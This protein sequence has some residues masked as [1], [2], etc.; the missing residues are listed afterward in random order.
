MYKY[1]LTIFCSLFIT[2]N[3]SAQQF[4][5]NQNSNEIYLQLK[6]LQ[7]C[8]SVLYIAAH[9]DDENNTLLP[10][11]AKEKLYRTAYLS[12]TRGDGGQNLI[13]PEQGVE[14][15]LIRT[16]ELVAARKIDGAEQYFTRAYEFGFSKSSDETLKIWDKEKVLADVVFVIRKFKPDVIITRFPPDSRAGHGHHAASAIIAHE[17]FVAAADKSKF[18]EQFKFGVNP[19][20]A[21]RIFWNTFNFGTTNTTAEN[22]LKIDVGG[23][24]T[25][26]GKSYGE[27]GAEARSMHKSQGEG[28]ARRRGNLI[29]YF[30]YVNG[31]NATNDLFE[32]VETSFKRFK[33][34]G[35][36]I[37]QL[38]AQAIKNFSF[39]QPSKSVSSLINIYNKIEKLEDEWFKNSEHDNW[40]IKKLNEVK[41]LIEACS[42]L[43]LEAT[44]TQDVAVQGDSLKVNFLAVNRSPVNISI[45]SVKLENYSYQKSTILQY[46]KPLSF[47]TSLLVDKEISQPYW[48]KKASSNEGMFEVA[49]QNLIGK[50]NNEAAFTSNFEIEID[51]K[52]FNFYKPVMYKY[53]DLVRGELYQPL[54]ILPATIVRQK[55]PLVI[56]KP[57]KNSQ[58]SINYYATTASNNSIN[59]L[60]NHQP[61]FTSTE[62]L[63]PFEEKEYSTVFEVSKNNLQ[64]DEYIDSF[65]LQN[66][67]PALYDVQIKYN[68]IPNLIY[69]KPAVQKTLVTNLKV[70]GNKV[71]YIVGAGDKVPEVLEQMGYLVD[72]LQEKDITINNLKQYQ[73]IICG[74]R[75]HNIHEWLSN[76]NNIINE[77]ISNGGNFIVQYLR[78]G[79]V[80]NK[81][82]AVG[83]YNFTVSASSRV[84][85]ENA[86]VNFLL[87]QHKVLN[88][89]N[90]IDSNDFINW[91][92]ERST[93]QADKL[94]SA[95]VSPLQ[96]NDANE[97]PS[98]GS[99]IIAP[100]G[101]GNM[102]YVSLAMFRQMP[103]GVNGALKLMSNI[104]ALQNNK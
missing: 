46:I 90:K 45:K 43:L 18:P 29:E 97:K 32:D 80:G 70:V 104:I 62:K 76:K 100:F 52:L 33:N 35:E 50:P 9:P 78:S 79:L 81:K 19:W 23:Y 64:L 28:R 67:Q 49:D 58:V 94:D 30:T 60:K 93:Y 15:G 51:G 77:Y 47:S 25:L 7:V 63:K 75:A 27:I 37:D 57:K 82:I 42:G 69:F 48:L 24:N 22:Q 91:V 84:T 1:I 74:I 39:E 12:L 54:P 34:G 8:G 36:E 26:L 20:Q 10:Y 40:K 5:I 101:K 41:D 71:G 83:P 59:I 87:P 96:M 86:P 66:H 31:A 65:Q 14:L 53:V 98:S 85:E 21:K 55:N 56:F 88:F 44:T 16:E 102:V 68:H 73:A 89:P 4:N 3:S 6:K 17:A 92:Q 103:A 99:L 95:F 61:W 11:F 72:V 2:I 38:I 13:G